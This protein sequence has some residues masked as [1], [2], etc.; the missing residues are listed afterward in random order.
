MEVQSRKPRGRSK[1][2]WLEVIRS[3]MKGM[4]IG[5]SRCRCLEEDGGVYVLTQ[6]SLELPWILPRISDC[7][8]EV[9]VG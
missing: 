3:D 7:K 1:K 9:C 8:I 2:T 4:G 5:H 6:V